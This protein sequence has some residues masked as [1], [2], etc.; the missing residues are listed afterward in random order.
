MPL[1]GKNTLVPE[2]RERSLLFGSSPLVQELDSHLK[3][4]LKGQGARN[5]LKEERDKSIY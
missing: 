1:Y 5:L 2:L 4:T 3:D